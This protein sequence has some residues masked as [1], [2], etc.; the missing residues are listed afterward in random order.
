MGINKRI[1]VTN[2]SNSDNNANIKCCVTEDFVHDK[3]QSAE[4]KYKKCVEFFEILIL[5]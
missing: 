3:K 1:S 2:I 4:S 5:I